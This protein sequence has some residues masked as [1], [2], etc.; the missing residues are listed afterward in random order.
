MTI[1]ASVV[2][3]WRTEG[4][5]VSTQAEGVMGA[6]SGATATSRG[7]S[8]RC[9]SLDA[10]GEVR[11]RRERLHELLLGPPPGEEVTPYVPREPPRPVGPLARWGAFVLCAIG[12]LI[13][14]VLIV[15]V[16]TRSGTSRSRRG[17]S[18]CPASRTRARRSRP[19]RPSSWASSSWASA[20]SGSSAGPSARPS[21]VGPGS[22]PSCSSGAIW[23]VPVLLGPP[24]LSN[25][26]Y[27]YASQGEMASRG[28][29]PTAT[30]P[31][32]AAAAGGCGRSTR[33]GV[34]RRPPTGRWR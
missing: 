8:P 30:G 11:T 4:N 14:A 10:T 9:A 1:C 28:L 12:G 31:Y 24:M 13:G 34:T 16:G 27:S 33:S 22:P 5:G 17:A 6:S 20:G 29:D 23:C 3:T 19:P 18:P 26:V 15:R 2:G 21:R 32:A 7:T 25:D